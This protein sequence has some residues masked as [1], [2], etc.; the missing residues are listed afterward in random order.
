MQSHEKTGN[1]AITPFGICKFGISIETND[2]LYLSMY[3]V[4]NCKK[5]APEDSSHTNQFNYTFLMTTD[6][7]LVASSCHRNGETENL[8]LEMFIEFQIAYSAST[9]CEF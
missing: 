1:V 5:N 3:H 6:I 9:V 7:V 8:K 4:A 2:C